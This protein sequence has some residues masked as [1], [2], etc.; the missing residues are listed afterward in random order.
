MS[1][2]D[3][4]NSHT[5]AL[6]PEL[7]RAVAV[8]LEE[9]A[10]AVAELDRAIGDG[11][12][13]VNLRRGIDALRARGDELAGMD[14][15]S[16]WQQI[17]MTLMTTVGGASGSLYGTLFVTMGKTARGRELTLETLADSFGAGVEAVKRRGRVEPGE[18]TLV[19]VLDPVAKA[20]VRL[21]QVE[22]PLPRLV[23][24]LGQVAEAGMEST[25]DLVATK[26]RASFLGERSRGWI[27][28]GAKTAQLMI[29]AV[30]QALVA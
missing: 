29:A 3:Q 4:P 17:G 24:E 9:N 13:L 26:G 6:L 2:A 10:E 14:W 22:A 18:K 19:D 28:P 8:A 23:E 5:A 20:L 27:D 11:D 1:S 25:R 7:L 21:A 30:G 12:H 16:A 15:P